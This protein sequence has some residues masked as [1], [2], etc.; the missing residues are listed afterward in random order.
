MVPR[1][2]WLLVPHI[3]HPGIPV[4]LTEGAD[5]GRLT[6]PQGQCVLLKP[7]SDTEI[8]YVSSPRRN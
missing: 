5:D 4:F 6:C 1:L 7:G 2:L 8:G 3:V